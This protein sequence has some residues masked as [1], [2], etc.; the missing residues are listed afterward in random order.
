MP[1]KKKPRP[2]EGQ[3][4]LF[5]FTQKTVRSSRPP[6]ETEIS[7]SESFATSDRVAQPST[8]KQNE[9][10]TRH[11]QVGW[12]HSYPWLS[13]ENDLMHCKQC[14]EL[15]FTN[16]KAQ[17]TNNSRTSTL[18]ID[19]RQAAISSEQW[20]HQ[21]SKRGCQWLQKKRYPKKRRRFKL[22]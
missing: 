19:M 20:Q 14:R 10:A 15:K 16:T 1:P 5:A 3:I 9:Q 11:F 17:G 8:S 12:L 4:T 18:T 22:L 21:M 13:Y 6:S 2:E 7:V